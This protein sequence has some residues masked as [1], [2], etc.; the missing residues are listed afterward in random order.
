[1]LKE[2]GS[3]E[4]LSLVAEALYNNL[5]DGINTI[6][7]E[8]LK[9]EF[10]TTIVELILT[11]EDASRYLLE[12][13]PTVETLE[14]ILSWHISDDLVQTSRINYDLTETYIGEYMGFSDSGNYLFNVA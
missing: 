12:Y 5:L 2:Y 13:I 11:Q 8:I 1:M 4:V 3:K 10:D 14:N 9:K 6:P 7:E